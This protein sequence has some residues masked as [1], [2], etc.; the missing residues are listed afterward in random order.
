[1]NHP[2]LRVQC[3]SE[4]VPHGNHS[5]QSPADSIAAC[6]LVWHMST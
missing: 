5:E 1:M 4:R 6:L 2:S 3:A